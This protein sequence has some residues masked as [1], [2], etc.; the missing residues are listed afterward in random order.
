M[1]MVSHQQGDSGYISLSY[2]NG[3]LTQKGRNVTKTFQQVAQERD[4]LYMISHPDIWPR[5][6]LCLKRGRFPNCEFARMVAF[7]GP[8]IHV[9]ND[10]MGS[11]ITEK[12]Y[13]SF[14]AIIDDGWEV[15]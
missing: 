5:E 14:Q 8:N 11:S 12:P 2:S 7:R 6:V 15:D 1:T 10:I 3:G 9:F 4:H 13:T